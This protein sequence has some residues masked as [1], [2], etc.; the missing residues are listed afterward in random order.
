MKKVFLIK[1]I[2]FILLISCNNNSYRKKEHVITNFREA[3]FDTISPIK[4]DTY[5]SKYIKVLGE[6]DDSIFVKYNGS[7]KFFL[8]G[9][10]DT[11]ISAD[12]YGEKE[13]IYEFNPYI[14]KKGKLKVTFGI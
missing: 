12:Y 3:I 6:T 9:K 11:L 7:Y 13:V 1:T 5:A 8:K 2:I 10:I 14:A 4:G